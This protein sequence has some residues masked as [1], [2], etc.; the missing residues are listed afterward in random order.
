MLRV[1]KPEATEEF[2]NEWIRSTL[3]EGNGDALQ[4]SC[5]ENPMDGEAWKAVAHGVTK[6]RTRLSIFTFTFH[7]HTLEK[8]MATHSSVL[9]WRIPGTEE[10]GGLQS[11]G[12][13][14][15]GQD[16]SDLAAAAATNTVR[17]HVRS[18]LYFAVLLSLSYIWLQVP[19]IVKAVNIHM[20]SKQVHTCLEQAIG[21]GW[22]SS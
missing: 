20:C 15:V 9:S 16:W 19:D 17:L 13:H 8:T 12:S 5:L 10:P 11:M 4:Y 1:V 14:R 6:S 21:I 7:F 2:C 22:K 3:G 18:G